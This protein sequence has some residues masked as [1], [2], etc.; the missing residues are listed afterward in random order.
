MAEGLE[1]IHYYHIELDADDVIVA[2][3]AL[4]ETFIDDDSRGLFHN[5]AEFHRLYPDAP[6]HLPARYRAP[7]LEEGYALEAL[8]REL[9]WRA[10]RL[11]SEG[12]MFRAAL[13]GHLEGVEPRRLRGWAY[14]PEAP[15]TPV[16]LVFLLN[17]AEIARLVADRYRP[18]LEKAGIGDGR[19]AFELDLPAGLAADLRHEIE[20]RRHD[21]GA[22]LSGCPAILD[23]ESRTIRSLKARVVVARAE[24]NPLPDRPGH[25]ISHYL[26][27]ATGGAAVLL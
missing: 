5:A 8:R 17:G 11:R 3:G 27:L 13:Q 15:E 12:T 14:D 19:H 7:R 1:E 10:R 4:A 9:A 6:T 2:E 21:D 26:P 20:V 18:D 25:S 22:T 23:P 16:V 24:Q